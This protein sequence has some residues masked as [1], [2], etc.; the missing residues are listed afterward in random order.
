MPAPVGLNLPRT[1]GPKAFLYPWSATSIGRAP[2]KCVA[3]GI[4]AP[5][6]SQISTYP[7]RYVPMG[8]RW[9]ADTGSV[10]CSRCDLSSTE[11]YNLH[12]AFVTRSADRIAIQTVEKT[13]PAQPEEATTDMDKEPMTDSK[14]HTETATQTL[15]DKA[16][17]QL[18]EL[19]EAA[20]LAMKLA[21]VDEG[22]DIL[23]D[24][25]KELSEDLPFM[26]ELLKSRE[27]RE[28]AKLT[29][30]LALHSACTYS[31]LIPKSD[32]VKGIMGLQVTASSFQ[33]IRPRLKVLRKYVEKLAGLGEQYDFGALES[34]LGNRFRV[35][36]RETKENPEEEVPVAKVE[37]LKKT[38]SRSR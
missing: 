18:H 23:L 34:G 13:V 38:S 14:G 11:F 32:A 29:I 31:D 27:G 3:C 17:G 10:H 16:K 20:S 36:E 5:A 25:A 28:F 4:E 15:G 7:H 6:D 1:T 24:I 26:E 8:W 19:G 12:D 22:G 2:C 37:P 9:S 30:A 33:L 35:E 21:A